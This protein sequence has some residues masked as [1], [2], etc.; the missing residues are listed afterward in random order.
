MSENN[1]VSGNGQKRPAPRNGFKK[2][3]SGNPGGRPKGLAET[4]RTLVGQ[5]GR[6]LVDANMLLAWGSAEDRRVFFG[7]S[8]KVQPKD[9]QAAIEW[10]GERGWGKPIQE[11]NSTLTLDLG[12]ALDRITRFLAD[13]SAARRA[14]ALPRFPQPD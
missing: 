5:D 7:E 10:L 1:T 11:V 13:V 4:V 14:A 3:R 8:V 9:R 12:P 6:K 2:G